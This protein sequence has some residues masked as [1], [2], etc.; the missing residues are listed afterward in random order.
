[1]SYW[2]L[3]RGGG[4]NYRAIS[5]DP[6]TAK[7]IWC[8]AADNSSGR[9]FTI[10][11]GYNREPMEI[12]LTVLSHLPALTNL[13][14]D[15]YSDTQ[16]IETLLTQ[17]SPTNRLQVLALE[18][19][20][21]N[22]GNATSLNKFATAL[23]AIRLPALRRLEILFDSGHSSLSKT[24]GMTEDEVRTA[25]TEFNR[26]GQLK[27]TVL[28]RTLTLRALRYVFHLP[29]TSIT[30]YLESMQFDPLKLLRYLDIPIPFRFF[31]T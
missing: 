31:T 1:M 20:D 6:Q 7:A 3:S 27:L 21:S 18:L 12:P 14:F 9:I 29:C 26:R 24:W 23:T 22:H 5:G 17:L 28:E 4:R 16:E 11:L 19:G 2:V 25:F 13:G 10:F 15:I 8:A 30:I